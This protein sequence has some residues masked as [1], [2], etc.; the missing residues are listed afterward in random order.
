[1][2]TGVK[3]EDKDILFPGNKIYS[4]GTCCIVPQK[5]NVLVAERKG[6]E[7][8]YPTGI[9]QCNNGFRVDVRFG[10]KEKTIGTYNTVEEAVG[11]YK[12]VKEK[13]IHDVAEKYKGKIP[14]IAYQSLKNWTVEITD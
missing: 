11:I 12:N 13:Y 2:K 14:E 3:G 5:I 6:L 9:Y 8:K 10:G 1:M 7:N 4:P